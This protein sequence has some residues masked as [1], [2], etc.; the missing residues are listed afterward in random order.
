MCIQKL[1]R[2]PIHGYISIP[3][4][5]CSAFIDNKIFQRLRR[6]EQTSM[7]VLYPS[8]HH[9]RFSHS[10]GVF[11]L[12]QIAVSY[13]L[14]NS[15]ALKDKDIAVKSFK[16]ACLLHDCAHSP[17]SHT[18][19]KYYTLNRDDEIRNRLIYNNPDKRFKDDFATTITPAPHEVVSA[20]VAI[21]IFKSDIEKLGGDVNLVARMITG[22]Q[23]SDPSM[24]I[25]NCLISLLNGS[26][27]DVDKLDYI[28]RDTWASG[29][30]NVRID[31]ERLL[32]SLLIK[33]D[34]DGIY[35]VFFGKH[36]LNVIKNVVDGRNFLY[37]WVYPH[38]KVEYEQYL[39]T[40]ALSQLSSKVS[41]EDEFLKQLFSINAL[42]EPTKFENFTF[43]LPS[44]GDIINY[45]KADIGPNAEELL[46]RAHKNRALWKTKAEYQHSLSGIDDT[47][48]KKIFNRSGAKIEEILLNNG[49][50]S[51]PVIREIKTK[52]ISIKKD[53]IFI[54]LN[55][56]ESSY[57]N[58][59][60][61]KEENNHGFYFIPYI[62]REAYKLEKEIVVALRKLK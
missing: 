4:D 6:I 48:R 50:E 25:E 45:L 17:F 40:S 27:I 55:G 19:E 22:C 38:H 57:T 34:K 56:E 51:K 42:Y 20:I 46:S 1:F 62:P 24:G 37:E 35:Q 44:D 14:L 29:I 9:D 26:A 61:E 12:G 52:L 16:M 30:N 54:D 59:F 43:Y 13:L 39:I 3:V 49:I 18:F 41:K 8:A 53:E 58:M 7:R 10:L 28:L 60:P 11:H 47:G 15:P 23:F 21:E 31:D 2:D 33:Q 36:A 5:Y 32:S